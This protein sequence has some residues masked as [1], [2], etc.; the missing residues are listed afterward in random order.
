[1]FSIPLCL[2]FVTTDI[3]VA[4]SVGIFLLNTHLISL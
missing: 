1:M 3:A 2:N 4:S